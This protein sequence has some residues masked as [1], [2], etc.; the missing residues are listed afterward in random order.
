VNGLSWSSLAVL[1]VTAGVLLTGAV[2]AVER[3]DIH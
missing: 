1:V 2:F 3:L